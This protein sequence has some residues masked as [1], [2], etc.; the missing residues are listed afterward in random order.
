MQ[1]QTKWIP[2][3]GPVSDGRTFVWKSFWHYSLRATTRRMTRGTR[4]PE[5]VRASYDASRADLLTGLDAMDWDSYTRFPPDLEDFVV[6]DGEIA[7]QPLR[8]VRTRLLER[9]ALIV[10]QHA[11]DGATVVEFGSGDGRNLLFLQ[12]RF[13]SMRFIGLELSPVSVEVS[14]RAAEKFKMPQVRFETANVCDTLPSLPPAHDV[15]LAFSSH[16]LEM[17]PRI[18]GRAVDNMARC[19]SDGLLF[20]EPVPELWAR[21]VRGMASRFRVS[22]LDRLRGLSAKVSSLVATGDWKLVTMQRL[23]MGVPL[24]ETCEVHVR[25]VW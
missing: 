16:A 4:T 2:A 13:P 18:F 9:L 24:N 8:A 7:W 11:R 10:D 20:F 21:D 25:R 17:M 1:Y 5:T 19:S 3:L 15:V 14:R 6:L 22:Y 23:G 12:R